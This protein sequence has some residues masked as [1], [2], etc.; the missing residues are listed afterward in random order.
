MIIAGSDAGVPG[1]P[2]GGALKE[3]KAYVDLVGMTAMQALKT[4][5]SRPAEVFGLG[6]KTGTIQPGRQADLVIFSANPAA[7]ISVIDDEK[8]RVAVLKAGKVAAGAL[9]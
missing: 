5:T 2:Q 8:S 4:L 7:D 3:A 1:F 6:E 9:P